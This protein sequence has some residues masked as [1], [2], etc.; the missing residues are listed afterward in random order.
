MLSCNL[1]QPQALNEEHKQSTDHS[2]KQQVLRE[3][4]R[5]LQKKKKKEV[6]GATVL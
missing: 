2:F 6:S 5:V 1:K 3:L 4:H